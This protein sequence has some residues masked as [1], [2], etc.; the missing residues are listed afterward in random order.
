MEPALTHPTKT[1]VGHYTSQQQAE[2]AL[3]RL[4]DSGFDIKQFTIVG[5]DLYTAEKI[6]GFYGI[7]D[8]MKHWAAIGGFYSGFWGLLF[9][10]S[11][12]SIPVIGPSLIQGWIGAIVAGLLLAAIGAVLSAMAAVAYHPFSKQQTMKYQTDVMAGDYLLLAECDVPLE[13]VHE[14]L[15]LHLP[16]PKHDCRDWREGYELN[17]R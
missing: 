11:N 12:Y 17:A 16:K 9:G 15:Q 6:L 2:N 3:L 4:Q 10:F 14:I 13:N 1:T 7:F 5:V 8:R